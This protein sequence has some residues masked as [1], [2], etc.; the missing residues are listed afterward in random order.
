M[1]KSG[2]PIYYQLWLLLLCGWTSGEMPMNADELNGFATRYTTAWNSEKAASVGKFFAED[3]GTLSVNGAP[4][5]GRKAIAA[6][7]QGFMTGF[8]DMVL[9]M[10]AL[11]IRSDQVIFRWTFVGTNTGPDGTG[12]DV[13]FSGYEKWTFGDDKLIARSMGHFD[14]DDYQNQLKFGVGASKP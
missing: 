2:K 9:T 6:V 3:G 11:E 7:A 14:N 13:H 4:A 5:V 12:N 10:D 1:L 8:P